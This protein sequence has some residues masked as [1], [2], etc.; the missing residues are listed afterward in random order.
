MSSGNAMAEK[1][2]LEYIDAA[3]AVSIMMI[4]Y[5]HITD[6]SNPVD[7]WM[8]SCKVCIFYVISGFLMA[9][10]NGL[11]KRTPG[12]FAANI[13]RSLAWPYIIFSVITIAV[14]SMY[15]FLKHDGIPSAVA[16]M[17]VNLI[18]SVFLEGINSLWFLPTLYLGEL[19]ILALFLSPKP[20]KYLFSLLG[21]FAFIPGRL[22]I[23]TMESS[24]MSEGT[25]IALTYL[26]KALSKSVVAAWFIGFGYVF[27]LFCRK[28]DLLHGHEALKLTA[29][30]VFTI[31]NV[32]LSL[33]NRGVNFKHLDMGNKPLL[34]IYGSVF[35]SLGIIL[36][37]DVLSNHVSLRH[38][39]YWGKN[40]LIL[41]CTHTGLGF[42]A[43]AVAGWQKV[44]Y[45]PKTAGLEY[46]V[47]TCAVLVLLLLMMYGV[48]EVINNYCPFLTKFPSSKRN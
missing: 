38:L 28:K 42:R 22:I 2:R 27:Y 1:K 11:G 30:L 39:N 32:F 25:V 16:L 35:G 44:A 3:K 48:I 26:V 37:L 45:I 31:S 18:K 20:V 8:S 34:F 43:M 21:L 40:S 10:T 15:V 13:T 23:S 47:E 12:Q 5:G 33:M 19:L 7:T 17:K 4:M 29:G 9:Y 46:F 36:L 14:K 6:I 24:G 41:M